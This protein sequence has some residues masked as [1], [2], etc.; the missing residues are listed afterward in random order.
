LTIV[1]SRL[2]AK[3]AT[4]RAARTSDLRIVEFLKQN[5]DKVKPL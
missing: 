2:I 5:L 1:V 3:A 4:R